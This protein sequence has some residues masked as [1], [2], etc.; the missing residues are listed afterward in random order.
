MC[1]RC[2]R[3][4]LEERKIII[5]EINFIKE[6]FMGYW[7]NKQIEEWESGRVPKKTLLGKCKNCNRPIRVRSDRVT[8]PTNSIT[9]VCGHLNVFHVYDAK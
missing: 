8:Y 9:C 3:R 4:S 5:D 1:T 2:L 7:K 6:D